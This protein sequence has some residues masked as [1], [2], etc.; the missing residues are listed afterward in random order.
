MAPRE[1]TLYLVDIIEAARAIGAFLSDRSAEE[2]GA[3]ELVASAVHSKLTSI[4]EAA[5][6][7]PADVPRPGPGTLIRRSA[8]SQ[9]SASASC[10]THR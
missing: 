6:N 3:D 10:P 5:A 1:P 4:G 9:G 8:A 2:F 7:V